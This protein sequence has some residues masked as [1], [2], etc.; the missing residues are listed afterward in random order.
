MTIYETAP[1]FD[2]V[3]AGIG[4]SPSALKAM[5]LM[6]PKFARLYDEIKVGNTSPERQQQQIEILSVEERFGSSWGWKGGS[7]GHVRFERSSARRRA[8][9][10][11]VK[12]LIPEGSVRFNKRVVQVVQHRR[13]RKVELVFAD[14]EKAEYDMVVGCDGIK[15]MTR[16]VVLGKIW[17][18]EVPAKYCNKYVY[19]G[20]APIDEA[21]KIIDQNVR[22]WVGK[23]TGWAMY[24][25]SQGREANIVAFIQDHNSWE[26][27]QVA[28]EVT[29]E[30][31]EVEF[32]SFDTRFKNLLLVSSVLQSAPPITM[33]AD[34]DTYVKPIKW[35]LF[36]H[37][38][39]PTYVNGRVCLLGNSAHTSSPSQA[40]GAGQG[41]E[42][43]LILSKLLG[44]VT[45]SSQLDAA[46]K[47]YDAIRRPR[48][49][50]VVQTSREAGL[51]YL[52]VHPEFG[53][54]LQKITVDANKR[55]PSFGGMTWGEVSEKQKQCSG[56]L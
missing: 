52:L 54:N 26:G 29:R 7:V 37:P 25:I 44:L 14:G 21:K 9:L 48:A 50:G 4:L 19:R 45:D 32:A 49:Q 53:G 36:H 2:A 55:L 40:A 6:D 34:C 3:G 10:E 15:G 5:E 30:E 27:E 33:A 43:A 18:E 11:A 24:H 16:G 47:V 31:M 28:R 22:W 20:I 17:P 13:R 56:R 8:L 46:L 42:G 12:G 1:R 38:D 51:E 23:G 41:L 39:T 35:P